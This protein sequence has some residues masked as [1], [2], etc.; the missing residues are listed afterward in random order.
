MNDIKK[1]AVGAATPATETDK[2]NLYTDIIS[3]DG[4]KIKMLSVEYLEHHPD[5]PRK[6]IGDIEELTDSIKKNGIMQNL[7]V[8]PADEE[9]GTFYV[10]I[11]NRRFEAAKRAGLEELPCKIVESLTKVEQIGIMLEENMQRSDL[12]VLEQAQGFQLMLDMGETVQGI[13]QRTGFSES[14]VRRRVKINELDSEA[15]A[16]A[17]ENFQL[18]LSDFT[19]LEKIEDVNKR[20]DLLRKSYS[21]D[22]FR[23]SVGAAVREQERWKGINRIVT[24]LRKLGVKESKC[25]QSELWGSKYET[26][27]RWAYNADPEKIK[28]IKN[29]DDIG[30]G[31]YYNEVFLLRETQKEKKKELTPEKKRQRQISQNKKQIDAAKKQMFSEFKDFVKEKFRD[32][33][34]LRHKIRID[35]RETREAWEVMIGLGMA[36]IYRSKLLEPLLSK[37][38][39]ISDQQEKDAAMHQLKRVPVAY[40]MA[41][42]A[43]S[44]STS[45][46]NIVQYNGEYNKNVGKFCER[47]YNLFHLWGFRFSGEKEEEFEALFDG[48]SKLYVGGTENG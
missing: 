47:L 27:K 13:A 43:C 2:E 40:Q 39:Y 9:L 45:D 1:S 25:K 48:T 29:T 3:S 22:N 12:T 17:A 32:T 41:W 11:G 35:E 36:D 44:R 46:Y 33:G 42:V 26:V 6:S 16:K 21:G 5:N 23:A 14:T 15:I 4:G 38:F 8:V 34:I 24:R 31:I 37:D 30:Y 18:T 10:L 28:D 7:T 19:E 20:N